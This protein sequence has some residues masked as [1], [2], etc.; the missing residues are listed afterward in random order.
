ML[1]RL[2]IAVSVFFVVLTVC[3]CVMWVRSYWYWDQL[4]NP[5]TN[6]HL[7]IVESA[8]GRVIVRL[9]ATSPGSSWIWHISRDLRGEYWGGPLKEWELANRDQGMGGFACY[10]TAWHTT[11]RAPYWFLVLPFT[12]LTA[13]PW[14]PWSKQF[15]LRTLFIVMTLIAVVLAVWFTA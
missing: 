8:S 9:T 14:L 1:R 3:M 10:V 2:R 11:Y 15:S 7:V 5:I 6:K 4:Y 12:V 13:A